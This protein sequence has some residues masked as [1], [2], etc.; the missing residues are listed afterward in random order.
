M[1]SGAIG[2]VYGNDIVNPF[3]PGWDATNILD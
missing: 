3:K 1:L 2:H